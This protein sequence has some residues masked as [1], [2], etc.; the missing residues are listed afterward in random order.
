MST[1]LGTDAVLQVADLLRGR[2]QSVAVAESSTAGL[3]SAS[4]LAVPGASS[5]FLGGSVVYTL[6]SRK[7]L[8][9]I[10]RADVEGLEPLT[11]AMVM[12]FAQQ[13]RQQLNATWGL[14]ELGV[15]GPTGARYGHAPGISVLAVDGPVP[16]STTIE[17]GDDNREANMWAFTQRAFTLF[18][19]ALQAQA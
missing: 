7:A 3:I 17:T 18:A 9:G 2:E 12:R 8:L 4:L 19:E 16:L 6:A 11:E 15:A 10:S 1:P 13:A 5:Y 14:A